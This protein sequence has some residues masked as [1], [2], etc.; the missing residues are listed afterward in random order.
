MER[1]R[2]T[3]EVLREVL[4]ETES[5]PTT[6]VPTPEIDRQ[7]E[8]GLITLDEWF[9]LVGEVEETGKDERM[10]LGLARCPGC[11]KESTTR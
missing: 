10:L 5:T 6:K 2:T 1:P 3:L 8:R 9:A 4:R 11:E 7:F